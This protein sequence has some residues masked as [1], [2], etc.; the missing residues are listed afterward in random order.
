LSAVSVKNTNLL[1]LSTKKTKKM[2][3]YR[4]NIEQEAR[5]CEPNSFK[6]MTDLEKELQKWK[7][8][9]WDNQKDI[10]RAVR[11]KARAIFKKHLE[12]LRLDKLMVDKR[13]EAEI[14][15][16]KAKKDFLAKLNKTDLCRYLA[17]EK[18]RAEISGNEFKSEKSKLNKILNGFYQKF[19]FNNSIYFYYNK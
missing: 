8:N 6:S 11:A 14:K 12:D 9:S 1:T 2:Q 16:E 13:V 3:K 19:N 5:A 17:T 10:T 18:R 4:N 15:L 7:F